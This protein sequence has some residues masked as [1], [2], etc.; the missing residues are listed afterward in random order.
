M[1][2][3]AITISASV[4]SAVLLT[5]LSSK[6]MQMLQLSSYRASGVITWF[7]ST[8]WN[9]GVR[10]FAAAFF[11]TVCMLVFVGCFGKY[12]YVEYI[13]FLFYITGAV[14]FIAIN[15][16]QKD[17]T[18]LR[19]TPRIIRLGILSAI[20][21]CAASFGLVFAGK[22]MIIKYS[23]VG[24]LPLFIPLIVL[25][26][27]F[28]LLPFESLN[29]RRY[30][31]KARKKLAAYK[32]LIKIG[33]TG[34]YGKTTAK[35]IL[36]AMLEKKYSVLKTPSSYNTPMGIAK[37]V[38][39]E[40]NDSHGVFIAEMGARYKGDIAKLARIVSPDI[41]IIT[42]VGNQHLATFKTVENI[43]SA[44][45]E[46]VKGLKEG[47]TAVFSSDNEYT[48]KMYDYTEGR[49]KLAG[50]VDSGKADVTYGE[51]SFGRDGTGFTLNFG[52]EKAHIKTL[53]LG[54][55]IPSLVS[56][57]AAVAI[58][59]GV[60]VSDIA[61]AVR[62]LKP[63]EH[64]LQLI[65]NGDITVIDDAYN[66]NTE[67][68]KIA[69]EVLGAFDSPRVIITP[70]L[71]ELGEEEN[72]ANYE[73]GCNIASVADYA[74]F[75]GSRAEDLRGGAVSA[76]LNE[77]KIAMCATL[78]E[79]VKKLIDIAGKKTVLFENDLPDNL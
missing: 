5:L 56:L 3:L 62:N 40:L 24:L 11:S 30:E 74:F 44:K 12:R 4:V 22:Y 65:E 36:A 29:N 69:L 58:E 47:G 76:G 48:L 60:S 68:V 46:L 50:K 37:T 52:N 26:A 27:H 59:L 7:K 54:R 33:I 61:D 55:H 9:Y 53:L 2:F 19:C 14:L 13:G 25:S 49:K 75:V 8:K 17:K 63:V 21:F 72:K 57:C 34:S 73:F 32:D 43:A 71:V 77:D 41:G 31:T 28:I 45:Y 16:K 20:L 67:G 79:A 70:G 1:E 64:R 23:L 6:I 10:Y 39:Y 78:D 42:A 35:N 66:S 15:K 38:N 18:P 51:V